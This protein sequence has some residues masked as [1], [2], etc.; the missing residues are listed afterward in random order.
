MAISVFVFDCGGV[1]LKP[2][3]LSA[4]ER[5]EDRLGLT[6]GTLEQRLW[7][8]EAWS[9]AERGQLT[10]E[11]FWLR[12]AGEVGLEGRE[13][14]LALRADLWDT[15]VV[16]DKVLALIDRIRQRYRVAMLSNATDALDDTLKARYQV[17]DR[18]EPIFNSAKM[19]LAKP[20]EAIF[21]EMLR[22]LEVEPAEVVFI[23]DRA[24]NVA[25]AAA[26]GMHVAWFIHSDELERQLEA[27]VNHKR[28]PAA[29][30]S[31]D[32][33]SEGEAKSQN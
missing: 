13:Q 30:A 9:M 6:R 28:P 1:V 24:E 8:G 17:A 7:T 18:F 11:E 32:A 23:D 22:Q 33:A 4:Y 26:L 19:G 3:D 21:Q 14:A 31:Q 10:D 25:A 20:D 29:T 12:V 27:Y 5:W 16:D 15:W 2:G